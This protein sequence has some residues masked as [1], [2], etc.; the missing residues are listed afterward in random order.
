M[1]YTYRY[2]KN[3]PPAKSKF[4]PK[5]SLQKKGTKTQVRRAYLAITLKGRDLPRV[6]VGFAWADLRDQVILRANQQNK[7]EYEFKKIN[8]L[9]TTSKE[10]RSVKTYISD[11]NAFL[12][13]AKY[14]FDRVILKRI[15][16]ETI[17]E[18]NNPVMEEQEIEIANKEKIELEKAIEILE[19]ID[20]TILKS[21]ELS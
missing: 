14:D 1:Q 5:S 7:G 16:I 21:V 12:L 3:K 2:N 10:K 15:L 4:V 8:R 19:D 17:E 18:L 9:Q 20:L 13:A 11:L 6:I